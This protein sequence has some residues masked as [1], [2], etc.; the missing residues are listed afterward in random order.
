MI[1]WIYFAGIN[2]NATF[3]GIKS[4]CGAVGSVLVWGARG[5]KFKSCH[6]DFCEFIH[7]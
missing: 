4:G 7:N 1:H 2:S 5:R 6:P 3:A